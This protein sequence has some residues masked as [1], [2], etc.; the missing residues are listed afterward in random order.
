LLEKFPKELKLVHKNYPLMS[1]RFALRA[2]EG[3]LAAN[4]QGK[5]WDFHK[6]LYE[7]F[8]TLSEEKINQIAAGL[9]LNMEKF[10]R[11]INSPEIRSL[12]LRDFNDGKRIGI[13]GVPT[14]FVNGKMAERNDLADLEAMVKEELKGKN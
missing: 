14:V 3:A 1:H 4:E 5:F 8:A 12:I 13:R 6:K 7:N 2:A 11:D 9:G 10:S